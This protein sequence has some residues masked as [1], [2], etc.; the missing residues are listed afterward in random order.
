M[1]QFGI[2]LPLAL[3]ASATVADAIEPANA[4]LSVHESHENLENL[5]NLDSHQHQHNHMDSEAASSSE[6]TLAGSPHHHMDSAASMGPAASMDSAAAN[7]TAS[8][9][10][11]PHKSKH[12]HG[13]SIL[14]MDLAPEERLFWESYSTET[15]F[16]TPSNHRGALY[17]HIASYVTS[18]MFLFPLVLVFWNIGHALYLPALTVHVALITV[19]A[20][21][22]W[23]FADSVRPDLY[24]KSAFSTMTILMFVGSL[25]HWLVALVASAYRALNIDS[26]YDYAEL[27]SDEELSSMHSPTLT[28]RESNSRFDSFELEDLA[29]PLG[30]GHLQTSNDSMLRSK[31]SRLSQALS[32]YPYLK[33]ITCCFG[34]VGHFGA[35]SWCFQN[36][37]WAWNHRFVTTAKA[38]SSWLKWQ[39]EGLCT[40]EMVESGLILFYGSTNIF[41]EHMANSGGEWS[42][43]DLQHASIAFIY[44]GC[45]LCGVLLEKMLATWR[46]TKAIQNASQVAESKQLSSVQKATPG[47]SPNPFPV[48]TIYWTGVLMSSHEQA[49]PI[50]SEIHKQWGNMFVLA[51]A[52]RVL[53]YVFFL[54]KP[55]EG[56]VLTKPVYPITELFVSFGLL[57]GGAIFMESC[58]SVVYSMEYYGVTPMFT[59]NLNLGFVALIMAWVISV[60]SIKTALVAR[61]SAH[62]ATV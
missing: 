16:T 28:L 41:M 46:F 44:I 18:Y 35:L 47:F 34:K 26:E 52:F 15:F 12:N 36:K 40:M 39:S 54:L 23:I 2:L 38:S 30:D 14:H 24:P 4:S 58:D 50:S 57:C 53:S 43:K 48:L 51:C 8:L 33:K 29:S 3:M 11:I 19:S 6:T 17:L 21:N 45:G 60:F 31:P 9:V 42:A 32:N 1:L 20:V 13:M 25:A 22:Y 55:I 7:S 37:G 49:S 5:E 61:M 59:L 62:G 10:P 56:K 27:E